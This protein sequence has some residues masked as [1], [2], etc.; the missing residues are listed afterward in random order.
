MHPEFKERLIELSDIDMQKKLWLNINNDSG[1]ISSYS[2]L[3]DSLYNELDCEIQEAEVSEL[4]EG[5]SQLKTMLDTYQE[6]ELYKNKYD[7][8]VILDDPNWQEIVRKT[9]ELVDHLDIK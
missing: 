1:L 7:D 3:Y 4:K 6:P 2:D 8:T 9:K 5:L